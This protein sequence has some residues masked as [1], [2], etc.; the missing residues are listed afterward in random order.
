MQQPIHLLTTTSASTFGNDIW[1][2][3]IENVKPQIAH[4]IAVGYSTS[5]GKEITIQADVFYKK[6]KNQI[7]YRQG[8]NFLQDSKLPWNQL[9]EKN[10]I[11]QA[12]GL[13]L[14]VSKE[15]AK[16]N[17][18]L[19]Y[20]LAASYRKFDNI[21]A[22]EWFPHRYDRRHTLNLIGE[23][24]LSSK[25]RLNWNFV[26]TTGNSVTLPETVHFDLDQQNVSEIYT[27]RNNFRMP[28]YNRTDLGFTYEYKTRKQRAAKWNFSVYNAYAYP[29]AFALEYGAKPIRES[30]DLFSP[31]V[32]RD[33][34]AHRYSIF[35]FIP[36][37]S[38]SIKLR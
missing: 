31:I 35:R 18:A 15:N 11:G 10:G 19:S 27:K 21:N 34:G 23:E 17:I 9:I 3:A 8:I 4:Q 1:V 22:G 20:T 29:N 5:I 7:D 33:G 26:L 16:R 25:W 24:K 6:L 12:A 14:Y 2:P 28:L 32:G 38:Y 36:G 37:V 30:A 13:E